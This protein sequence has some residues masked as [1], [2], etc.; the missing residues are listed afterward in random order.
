[1]ATPESIEAELQALE[2]RCAAWRQAWADRERTP[3]A[4]VGE[5]LSATHV[6]EP[7][8]ER[9]V[10][11]LKEA[12]FEIDN[13]LCRLA[14]TTA[15]AIARLTRDAD[16]QPLETRMQQIFSRIGKHEE[17]FDTKL[18]DLRPLVH[19]YLHLAQA[20]TRTPGA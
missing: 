17:N 8:A 12:R 20:L 11:R 4:S 1:M 19:R 2:Q 5:L 3:C 18:A 15:G 16:A 7:L 13:A 9:I 14:A 6:G 10:E